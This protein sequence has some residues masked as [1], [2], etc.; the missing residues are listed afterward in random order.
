MKYP[1]LVAC[2]YNPNDVERCKEADPWKFVSQLSWP[3]WQM[4]FQVNAL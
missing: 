1:S 2:T 4:K 3:G